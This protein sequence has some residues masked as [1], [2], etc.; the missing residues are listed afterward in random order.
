[1]AG[2]IWEAFFFEED[3]RVMVRES[4]IAATKPIFPSYLLPSFKF[5]FPGR[6]RRSASSTSSTSSTSSDFSSGP[7]DG[8]LSAVTTPNGSPP[9]GDS[10]ITTLGN[11]I[12]GRRLSRTAADTLRCSSCATDIAFTSQIISKGFTGR[13][14]RAYLISPLAD[15]ANANAPSVSLL[16]VRIGKNEN[17]QLVTGWHVVADICCGI[18]SRKLGWKYVDAKEESQKYKVGKFILETERVVTHRSWEDVTISE[19]LELMDEM[20][21]EEEEI[22]RGKKDGDS[23]GHSEVEFDSEDDEECEAVFA[24]LWDAETAA[25]RRSRLGARPRPARDSSES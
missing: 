25:K 13:Y 18:C 3:I 10:A 2:G 4:G 19:G 21:E 20:A 22:A 6:R 16:N 9:D 7:G 5:T 1:M 12:S 14:G 17:R 23:Q 11:K 8:A 15:S 24:G